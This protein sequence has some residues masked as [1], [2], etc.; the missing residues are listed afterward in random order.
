MSP[1]SPRTAAPFL[2]MLDIP[3]VYSSD[4]LMILVKVI[5][6]LKWNI[7]NCAKWNI[8]QEHGFMMWPCCLNWIHCLSVCLFGSCWSVSRLILVLESFFFFKSLT[9]RIVVCWRL[10]VSAACCNVFTSSH[11]VPFSWPSSDSL[12][13]ILLIGMVIVIKMMTMMMMMMDV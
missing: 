7:R 10:K 8:N 11:F 9:F 12:D 13:L 5:R 4:D 6:Y 1:H 3:I 2:L